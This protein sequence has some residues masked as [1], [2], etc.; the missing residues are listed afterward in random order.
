MITLSIRGLMLLFAG[1]SIGTGVSTW[2]HFWAHSPFPGKTRMFLLLP[3]LTTFRLLTADKSSTSFI[4][5]ILRIYFTSI[6]SPDVLLIVVLP[7]NVPQA[8]KASSS[9]AESGISCG[10]SRISKG[11]ILLSSPVGSSRL[12]IHPRSKLISSEYHCL[13]F[14]SVYVPAYCTTIPYSGSPVVTSMSRVSVPLVLDMVISSVSVALGCHD[15]TT[16][17]F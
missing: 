3:S 8:R 17:P 1:T 14:A 4:D 5:S 9:A 10:G 11:D 2:Y 15:K 13:P 7:F 6:N 12:I 16:E